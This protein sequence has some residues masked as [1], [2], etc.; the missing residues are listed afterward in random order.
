MV[1]GA[2]AFSDGSEDACR[3]GALSDAVKAL[4]AEERRTLCHLYHSL[5]KKDV[6]GALKAA[7]SFGLDIGS[8]A[9]ELK[10]LSLAAKGQQALKLLT[11]M[12]DTRWDPCASGLTIE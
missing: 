8:H 4:S 11:I 7:G 6:R 3:C 2:V 9:E 12:F 10:H 5:A 1:P